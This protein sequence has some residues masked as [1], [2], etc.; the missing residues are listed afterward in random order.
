M[1]SLTDVLDGR[2]AGIRR[3]VRAQVAGTAQP[4]AYGLDREE[5]RAQVLGQLHE[6]AATG[7][8]HLGFPVAYGG[9]GDIGG[10]IVAF[11]MLGF[12]DL[13]LMVK[14]GVQWGLFGGAVELLGTTEHHEKYLRSIM[15]LE[16]PGCF[17]MTEYGHGSD[18]QNLRTTATYDPAAEE[19]VIHTPDSSARKEY[20]G[21]AARDGRMA[22]VFAQLVTGGESRGVHAFLVPI[23]DDAGVAMPGVTIEDCGHKAGLNGVDNGRLTFDEVR[24]PRTALLNRYG[25]VAPD[26]TYASPIESDGKRFFTMLGTLVRGR[27]SVAG[28][29]GSATK[30]A[31]TIAVRYGD[32]RTQFERPGTDDEVVVLDYLGHQRKLLPALATTYALHFA[33]EEL[34]ATLDEL[35]RTEEPDERAR[36]ELES[37]AAGVKAVAT[38][39][40]TSTIQAAREACGG[41]GYLAE[42]IL[43]QLK[44]DTDVFTTFEGDNTVL[45][46]LVAKGLLTSYKQEVQDLSPLETARFVAEQV[47][48]TVIERTSARKVIERIMDASPRRDDEDSLFDRAWQIAAFEDRE[49]HVLDSLVKRLRKVGRDNS[50]EV[51][52][53]AQDHVLRAGRVHV[54]RIVLEAFVG[55]IDRCA[56]PDAKALLERVCDLY[57]LANIE[58]DRAWFLEHGRF[59]A[60]RAKAVVAAVNELCGELRPRARELVDAFAVPEQFLAAPIIAG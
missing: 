41:A 35:Q 1:N 48:D 7:R 44:A 22:A 30:R 27:V 37:H 25:D 45:L 51:F 14:A 3:D 31:L 9:K 17:A 52:N 42:N 13:S 36:R 59:T 55:A 50:F 47:V 39:H 6:L 4:D 40:A 15:D 58:A 16:L 32:R 11:E 5:H 57:A 49:E 33:Q 38:W 34:V 28:S 26:G 53:S 56:D 19:F 8:P 54:D 21:N 24:V 10:T 12:G 23:R 46:Q 60:Q 20:I 18:V 29:A 2:W 43:P